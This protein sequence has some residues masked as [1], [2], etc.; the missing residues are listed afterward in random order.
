MVTSATLKK[1]CFASALSG[2][3]AAGAI[4]ASTNAVQRF[5]VPVALTV[6]PAPIVPS[7]FR[8]V[9][10]GFL[11]YMA[12]HHDQAVVMA[13]I[14]QRRASNRIDLL[15]DQITGNQLLEIGEMKGWLKMWNQPVMPVSAEMTWMTANPKPKVRINPAYA[16]LCRASGGMP[17]MATVGELDNLRNAAGEELEKI[18]LQYMI[19]HHQGAIPMLEYAAAN[20]DE[21]LVRSTAGRMMYEQR[22]EINAM[23]LML[24]QLKAEP[25]P[26]PEISALFSK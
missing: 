20:A 23:R 17:G 7:G 15:A 8:L 16:E 11:Q 3:V 1:A 21:T 18:F 26:F 19:R 10:I 22:K 4:M 5:T 25:L 2:A 12:L 24:K 6:S 14:V 9:D 13:D